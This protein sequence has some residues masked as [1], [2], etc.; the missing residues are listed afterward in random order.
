MVNSQ[1]KLSGDHQNYDFRP[2]VLKKDAKTGKTAKILENF[3]RVLLVG[4]LKKC[5]VITI[6]QM[7]KENFIYNTPEEKKM[8][9]ENGRVKKIDQHDE[10]QILITNVIYAA[11][12]NLGD[13]HF[14]RFETIY[15]DFSRV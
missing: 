15:F 5:F 12:L 1:E 14:V 10:Y 9:N 4:N 13:K 8:F 6:F 3:F 7:Q 2:E 11:G